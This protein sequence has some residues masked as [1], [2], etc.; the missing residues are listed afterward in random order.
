M[1]IRDRFNIILSTSRLISFTIFLLSFIFANLGPKGLIISIFFDII[2]LLDLVDPCKQ[3]QDQTSFL[4]PQISFLFFGLIPII[5]ESEDKTSN[6]I[7]F[8]SGE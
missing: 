2:F 7:S 6:I 1:C 4:S 5:I 3:L 8:G